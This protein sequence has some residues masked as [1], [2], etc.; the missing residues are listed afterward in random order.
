M[1]SKLTTDFWMLDVR[2]AQEFFQGMPRFR[3]QKHKFS[4]QGEEGAN[5]FLSKTLEIRQ[6]GKKGDTHN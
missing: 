5:S 2:L 3:G 1:G 6:A 4:T